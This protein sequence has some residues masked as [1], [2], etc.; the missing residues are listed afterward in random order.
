MLGYSFPILLIEDTPWL[1]H[2]YDDC[3]I[4]L[5]PLIVLTYERAKFLEKTLLVKFG[6]KKT[7]S[8]WSCQRRGIKLSTLGCSMEK[9]E[10]L[11][12]FQ[13][14]FNE[15]CLVTRCPHCQRQLVS[16]VPPYLNIRHSKHFSLWAFQQTCHFY[17][18]HCFYYKNAEFTPNNRFVEK[19]PPK[20]IKFFVAKT[21]STFKDLSLYDSIFDCVKEGHESIS[22]RGAYSFLVTNIDDLT[23]VSLVEA[24]AM[25]KSTPMSFEDKE[26]ELGDYLGFMGNTLEISV[27]DYD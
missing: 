19:G 15:W 2:H 16:I 5:P 6:Y 20:R 14:T 24:I 10:W 8:C 3:P 1:L 27:A 9:R 7:V 23:W 12:L 25:A 17:W 11:E 13:W 4:Q 18:L 26:P 22:P 21:D